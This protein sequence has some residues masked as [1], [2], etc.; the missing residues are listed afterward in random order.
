M[1]S[2]MEIQMRRILVSACGLTV[3]VAM[4]LLAT[5]SVSGQAAPPAKATATTAKVYTPPR[6]P[7]GQPDLQGFWTNST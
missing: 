2:E 3:A 6:T 5:V 4:A 1:Q 7:D